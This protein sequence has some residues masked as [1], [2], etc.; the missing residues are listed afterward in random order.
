MLIAS[1]LHAPHLQALRSDMPRL[2]AVLLAAAPTTTSGLCTG[3]ADGDLASAQLRFFR[4]N[5]A[6]NGIGGDGTLNNPFSANGHNS[7]TSGLLETYHRMH[8][9]NVV[10]IDVGA[11]KGIESLEMLELWGSQWYRVIA[12]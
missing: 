10:L 8:W 12:Q 2:L 5:K 7:V 9:A 11:N 3:I 6:K 4:G 1:P